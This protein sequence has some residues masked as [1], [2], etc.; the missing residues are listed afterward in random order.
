VKLRI[1]AS[2]PLPFFRSKEK[3]DVFEHPEGVRT[4][5]PT[6]QRATRPGRVAPHLVVRRHPVRLYR[7]R[8]LCEP[9]GS[10]LCQSG[11]ENAKKKTSPFPSFLVVSSFLV[12][13][14]LD[15]PLRE[16]LALRGRSR[17]CHVC[18]INTIPLKNVV[19]KGWTR[20]WKTGLADGPGTT[21]DLFPSPPPGAATHVGLHIRIPKKLVDFPLHLFSRVPILFLEEAGELVAP[22]AER[23]QVGVSQLAP[24]RFQFVR[25]MLP[26]ACDLIPFH[27]V[28]PSES[29][30]PI[31]TTTRTISKI[32]PMDDPDGGMEGSRAPD[33]DRR[34]PWPSGVLARTRSRRAVPTRIPLPPFLEAPRRPPPT[35]NMVPCAPR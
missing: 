33:A 30:P 19:R 21:S 16:N 23:R 34:R 1:L 4:R 5:R 28:H 35:E 14:I 2:S 10:S 32:K 27:D 22:A 29:G 11:R 12:S 31:S 7:S 3:A 13:W 25:E 8:A 15:D 18:N 9:H 26:V 6:R 24:L 17:S 20:E